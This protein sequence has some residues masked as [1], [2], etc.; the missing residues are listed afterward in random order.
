M[1][2]LITEILKREGVATI[3]TEGS[4]GAHVTATWNSYIEYNSDTFIFPAGGLNKTE[5]NIKSGSK[6]IMLI[7]SKEV[8]GKNSMGTGFRLQGNAEFVYSG[9]MLEK[10]KNNFPWARAA[11]LFHIEN[12]EQLL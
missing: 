3:V 1:E 12:S 10:L 5:K 11:V 6:L 8:R 2:Q 4:D 7:G 9:A